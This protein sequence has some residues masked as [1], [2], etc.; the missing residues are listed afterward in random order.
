MHSV[1]A[2][3][4]GSRA[5][6]PAAR[7]RRAFSTAKFQIGSCRGPVNY[8]HRETVFHAEDM[9]REARRKKGAVLAW[10]VEGRRAAAARAA[11]LD[12]RG[13][14]AVWNGSV[15]VERPP[16]ARSKINAEHD[17]SRTLRYNYR[18]EVLPPKNLPPASAPSKWRVPAMSEMQRQA[19]RRRRSAEP[20][21]A[22]CA[23][24]TQE[25]PVH[26][27]LEGKP[28]WDGSVVYG[29]VD[30][31]AA[32]A[33]QAEASRRNSVRYRMKK[34]HVGPV[35]RAALEAERIRKLKETSTFDPDDYHAARAL[36]AARS[37]RGVGGVGSFGVG[38]KSADGTADAAS[39]DQRRAR[40]VKTFEHSGVYAYDEREGCHMWSDTGSFA[41]DSP[42]DV[43][44][45]IR[46]GAYNFAGF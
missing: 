4:S 46:P 11:G 5:A 44:R 21:R 34:P 42:G 13:C 20:L 3:F 39:L 19:L 24:S 35:R 32:L 8:G 27:A 22:G 1:G 15:S 6:P 28:E 17:R 45:S 37:I 14:K 10:K 31:R 43:V 18:A 2:N 36:E 30:Y 9:P 41:K 33:A 40:C 38:S 7:A 12:D 16:P 25:M 23:R 26:P 29:G